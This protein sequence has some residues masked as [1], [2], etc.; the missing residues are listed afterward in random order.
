MNWKWGELPFEAQ[1]AMMGRFI[2]FLQKGDIIALSSLLN[3][4]HA[5]DY[6]WPENEAMKQAVFSCILKNVGHN[7]PV[8][9]YDKGVENVIYYLAKS[10]IVWG[11]IQDD[12]KDSLFSGIS[13]CHTSFKAQAIS[14]IIY[15]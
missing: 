14:Y 1:E 2:V 11:D 3:G 8:A 13:L 10:G 4:F 5:M 12:V 15:G 9:R 7:E 6:R